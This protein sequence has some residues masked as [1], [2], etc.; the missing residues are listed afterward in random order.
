MRERLGLRLRFALFFAALAL[1][2]AALIASGLW[3]GYSRYGGPVEG[4]VIAGLIAAFGLFGISAWIGF[5]FD[6]NVARPVLALASDLQTRARA[7]VDQGIDQDHTIRKSIFGILSA[8]NYEDVP[9]ERVDYKSNTIKPFSNAT[10]LESLDLTE[11]KKPAIDM[12]KKFVV[13][14]KWKITNIS[15]RQSSKTTQI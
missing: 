2:G 4:Y 6:E 14:L 12:T 15:Y 1:A 10:L 8:K 5:L 13:N 3:L 9:L 7:K 11:D